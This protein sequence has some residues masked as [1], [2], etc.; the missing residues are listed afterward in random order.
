MKDYNNKRYQWKLKK[1]PLLNT[2]IIFCPLIIKVFYWCLLNRVQF[3]LVGFYLYET[4]NHKTT[5]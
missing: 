2:K 5:I 3:T 4:S 1:T